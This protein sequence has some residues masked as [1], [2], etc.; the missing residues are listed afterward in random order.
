MTRRALRLVPINPRL[1][2]VAGALE[3]NPERGLTRYH[4]GWWH[5][6]PSVHRGW[7]LSDI[8]N[9][10]QW[11]ISKTSLYAESRD[12][13]EWQPVDVLESHQ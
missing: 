11:Y 4:S 6:A 12:D 13:M 8:T 7:S 1:Q 10:N 3:T 2:V 9:S 5:G